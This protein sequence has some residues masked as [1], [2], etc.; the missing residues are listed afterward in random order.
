L[1]SSSSKFVLIK[2]LR[3]LSGIQVHATGPCQILTADLALFY[4]LRESGRPVRGTWEYFSKED[5]EWALRE[6]E[7]LKEEWYE[8]IESLVYRGV[9]AAKVYKIGMQGFFLEALAS[10]RIAER[11]FKKENPA[12]VILPAPQGI[13]TEYGFSRRS[14]VF[15][16]CAKNFSVPVEWAA[17]RKEEK[18][19]A[20]HLRDFIPGPIRKFRS[21][22]LEAAHRKN[23]EAAGACRYSGPEE[24]AG[25]FEKEKGGKILMVGAYQSFFQMLH[26]A[27]RLK[28]HNVLLVNV[29]SELDVI[30]ALKSHAYQDFISSEIKTP[31]KYLEFSDFEKKFC[32]GASAGSGGKFAV[33]EN[34]V[35]KKFPEIFKNENLKFHFENF[36]AVRKKQIE[37]AVDGA[38]GIF[39]KIRPQLL[40]VANTGINEQVFAAVSK[41]LGVPSILVPHNKTWATP[42]QY[43]YPADYLLV[44]SR[45]AADLMQPIMQN[46]RVIV[47][48]V[49][50]VEAAAGSLPGIKKEG[51]AVEILVLP[52]AY[53]SGPAQVFNPGTH[54][55]AMETLVKESG[56]RGWRIVF[57]PHPRA[58]V[59]GL[60]REIAKS[61][62]NVRIDS[63]NLAER[64]IEKTDIVL[65]L[66]YFSAPIY[67]AWKSKVPVISW[68][69]GD[70]YYG[71]HDMFQ[72]D[73]FPQVKSMDELEAA[74][75]RFLK[76]E[77]W[78][79]GWI[80]KGYQLA[81]R[82]CPEA[83]G[84]G[85][86]F[87]EFV[88]GICLEKA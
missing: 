31:F 77:D 11:F 13:P 32:A 36:W 38:Y 66:D 17:S 34:G 23:Q 35:S 64:L 87:S 16:Y 20:E 52:G 80:E 81:G 76:D 28:K 59:S 9:H 6:S 40:F 25:S 79:Q 58:A 29:G 49:A 55:R 75:T 50:T 30:E 33:P 39:E 44:P 19:F 70:L 86:S 42:D 67:K 84:P 21:R 51:N 45:G 73:W 74:V 15:A 60:V 72:R 61:Q 71:P 14:D 68:I 10:I 78:K 27:S 22:I 5:R 18:P 57:R 85:K 4:H 62:K 47:D 37:S 7:V 1:I 53:S 26:V 83:G 69:S 88:D 54:L 63:E 24:A 48:G 3:D 43:D 56:K 41:S 12:S 65:L 8:G 82:F 46:A 2:E